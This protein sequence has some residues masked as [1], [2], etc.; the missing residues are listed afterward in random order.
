MICP[1]CQTLNPDTARFC[2]NCGQS[3]E[4]QPQARQPEGERKL[5]TVLFADVVGSTAMGER[6]DPELITEVMNGAFKRMNQAVDRYGGTV[7]RLMGDAVLAIFGA[8][9]SH[10]DDPERAIRAGLEIVAA[11]RDYAAEID[12][13]YGVDFQVRVG[14]HTGLAVLDRVGDRIRA[15][16]TAM[17]D[18]PNVAA[19]M[20]SAAAPGTVLVSADTHRL[21]QHAF[22]FES[23]GRARLVERV[24][25]VTVLRRRLFGAHGIIREQAAQYR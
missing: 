16:Y 10:E 18:T 6:L 17:G 19:R 2:S 5:V 24:D 12:R 22:D 1:R 4:V 8:P 25:R 3:L 21:T 7:S 23:R 14:I 9:A 11:A 20:Q 15:E 13:Q